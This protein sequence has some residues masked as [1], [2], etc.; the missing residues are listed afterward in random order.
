[1]EGGVMNLDDRERMFRAER[2]AAWSQRL[3]K[4]GRTER[5]LFVRWLRQSPQNVADML[6]EAELDF[7]LEHVD[8]E[9]K[10]DV[11]AL[12]AQHVNNVLTLNEAPRAEAARESQGAADARGHSPRPPVSAPRTT[13][14][15]IAATAASAALAFGL[16]IFAVRDA[17]LEHS[18]ATEASEWR[19][20][21]LEDG[22]IV[23]LGPRTHVRIDFSNAQ[24]LVVLSRGEAFFE[25]ARDAARPFLVDGGLGIARALGT[26]FAVARSESSLLITVAEGR[27][28]VTRAADPAR[29]SARAADSGVQ[30]SAGQ[31]IGV[32]DGRL[33]GVQRVEAK[34]VLAWAQ[35]RLVFRTESIGQASAQFNRRNRLQ[36]VIDDPAI[37]AR[38]IR[39]VFDADDP[40]GFA[41]VI[42]A[43][44]GASTMRD[45]ADAVRVKSMEAA[46]AANAAAQ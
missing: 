29:I 1:M 21:T 44:T 38:P 14:R 13:R 45:G 40:G 26:E 3:A 30:L 2:A 16:V 24:R 4:A 10:M 8:P 27:V 19:N 7:A 33:T 5:T 11:D 41:D 35:K 43:A 6:R 17:V 32:S 42:A 22:S 34:D 12:A 28:F 31:Q 37:A 20:V 25:V 46:R 15:W 23:R 39:G 36:I 9:R 18:I